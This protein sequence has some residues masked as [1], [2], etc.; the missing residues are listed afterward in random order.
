MFHQSHW[1]ISVFL[2]VSHKTTSRQR[3]SGQKVACFTSEIKEPET[4]WDQTQ[5]QHGSLHFHKERATHS[6]IN[7]T[8][9]RV[10]SRPNKQRGVEFR[11]FS[12]LTTNHQTLSW[13]PSPPH[14]VKIWRRLIPP[15]DNQR[16]SLC[17][18]TA[19]RWPLTSSINWQIAQ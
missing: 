18:V 13:K 4:H 15:D 3:S 16:R 9:Q 5:H 19:H 1:L 11:R 2:Q 14:R 7:R 6:Q 17:S 8:E 12:V 10:R